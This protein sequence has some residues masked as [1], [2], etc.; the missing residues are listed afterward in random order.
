M[1]LS[2]TIQKG[3]NTLALWTITE[4]VSFF[5]NNV[6]LSPDELQ[7]YR[8]FKN[9]SRKKEWLAVRCLLQETLKM[10]PQ[11]EYSETGKPFLKN[12]P[13]TLSI[14]H[15]RKMAGILLSNNNLTGI[16]IEE[17]TRPIDKVASRFLS[18][19]EQVLIEKSGLEYGK[20]LS[21]CTKEA[22]F[23][24]MNHSNVDFSTQ[25]I[26]E[27]ISLDSTIEARFIDHGIDIKIEL[28]YLLTNQHAVV[29]TSSK[30]M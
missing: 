11:I 27:K 26:I 18:E 28:E 15:S 9:E 25:I 7:I 8:C 20:I 29:W 16:D 17:I 23:K 4:S 13:S 22:V 24:A 1:P 5:E 14:S 2:A 19:R 21:W 30:D 6:S 10:K 12:H 3:N